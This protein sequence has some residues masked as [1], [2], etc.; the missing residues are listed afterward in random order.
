V[1]SQSL[2]LMDL[3]SA[4]AIFAVQIDAAKDTPIGAANETLQALGL[5]TNN[6]VASAR[7][8]N[9]GARR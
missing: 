7:T 5:K 9:Q 4:T 1:T 2:V 8:R 3:S 6:D